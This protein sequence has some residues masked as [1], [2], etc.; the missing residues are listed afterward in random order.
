MSKPRQI[1]RKQNAK[2][3]HPASKHVQKYQETASAEILSDD[4]VLDYDNDKA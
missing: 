1:L 4:M 3:A 2:N